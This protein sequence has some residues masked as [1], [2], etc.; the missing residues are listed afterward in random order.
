MQFQ[1]DILDKP[2]ERAADEETTAFGAAVLAGLATDSER[3]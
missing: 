1:A 3:Y 2:V